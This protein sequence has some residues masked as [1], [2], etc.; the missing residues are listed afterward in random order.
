L[1][2]FGDVNILRDY[3]A[4]NKPFIQARKH[5]SFLKEFESGMTDRIIVVANRLPVTVAQTE[6]GLAY[7]ASPGGLVTA[8]SSLA[9]KYEQV[10]IGW[11]GELDLELIDQEEVK[12]KL[13]TDFNSIPV[14][15]TKP[16]L[17][18]YYYGF[19]N[20]VLWPVFHY[21]PGRCEYDERDWRTYKQVNEIFAEA[22]LKEIEGHENDTIWIHDYQLMLVPALVREKR[23]DAKIG[24]FLHTPFPSSEVFR[25]IPYRNELLWGILGASVIG[26]HTYGY[27][28]HFRS[29]LLRLLGLNSEMNRADLETHCA[30][31]GVYPISIDTG[32]I[33][34]L[35]S[36]NKLQEHTRIVQQIAKGRKIIIS[37]DRLDYT[38]G[39]ANRLRGYK[40]FLERNP[41]YASQAVFVQ[42][43][44]PSRTQIPSYR[45]LKE[46]VEEIVNEINETYEGEKY[47]PIHYMYRSLPFDKLAAFYKQAEISLVTP[48][49]DG[50][51]LV[52]KEFVAVQKD[53]G[54]LI[55]SEFAGAASELGEAIIINPWNP[56]QIADAIES[57]FSMAPWERSRRMSAMYTKVARNDVHYWANSFLADLLNID[58][59]LSQAASVTIPVNNSIRDQIVGEF[60]KAQSALILLDYDGTLVDFTNFPSNARPD[61]NLIGILEK[62]SAQEKTEVVV[63]TGRGKEDII[64]WLSG[65]KLGLSLE[66]GLWLKMSAEDEWFKSIQDDQKPS[67]YESVKEIFGQF[68]RGTP[69]SFIEEKEYS[70]AWHYRLSDPEFGNWQARE[71][72]LNLTN[73]LANKQAEILTGKSVVEVRVAGVNKGNI[74]NRLSQ[75]GKKHDF[76]LALGDDFTDEDM[77]AALPE[78]AYSIKIGTDP[79][80]AKY[81][82][83]KVADVRN[84]LNRLV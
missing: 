28:R 51:N 20:K 4:S 30:K 12:T 60:K 61:R 80:K 36:T 43:A 35:V 52:A 40:K 59:K 6:E 62:L 18:R 8:L 13:K 26:F 15:L 48:L 32:A 22:I 72:V 54:V 17:N 31:L 11:P 27:L 78:T 45:D 79:S 34:E 74:M 56:D 38:K 19:S 71:L 82:V 10:W 49:C 2:V 16:Q 29:S 76:I 67:W 23:P 24:F 83:N 69:G 81:R 63:V 57:A 42:I 7:K 58:C 68:S 41:K 25:V 39:I 1:P 5:L 64:E 75:L 84:L 33:Q 70:I 46:E 9:G 3:R 50:M 73:L 65:L 66:H 77:F 53:R 37:V 47:P 44:V 21:L 14:F 55:L